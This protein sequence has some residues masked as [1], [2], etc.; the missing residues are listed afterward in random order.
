DSLNVG[1]FIK[2]Y[3][4]NNNIV[5]VDTEIVIDY[6]NILTYMY[7]PAMIKD[8]HLGG[9]HNTMRLSFFCNILK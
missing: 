9:G 3:N 8:L 2:P 5:D 1:S 4:F 7:N 6:N